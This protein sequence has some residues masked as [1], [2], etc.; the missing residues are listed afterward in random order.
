VICNDENQVKEAIK[1]IIKWSEKNDL[2]I[3]KK[4]CGILQVV[5]PRQRVT[6]KEKEIIGIPTVNS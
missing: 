6:L 5:A 2:N 1:V 4:K 3:N